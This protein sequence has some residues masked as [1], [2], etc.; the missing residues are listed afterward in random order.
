M[1][2]EPDRFTSIAIVEQRSQERG[3]NVVTFI[4]GFRMLV[5]FLLSAVLSL[6]P[7]VSEAAEKE[8]KDDATPIISFVQFQSPNLLAPQSPLTIKGKL[9]LPVH[10]DANQRCFAAR[11]DVPAVVILHGSNGVD[12]RG[13]FYAESLNAAGIATL[14]IDMWEAR[15]VVGA[16]NR[17]PLPLFTYPDAFS[18][19]A[20]LSA[21]PN[22]APGRIGVLGFSWGGV[23]S[24]ASAEQL[25]AGMFGGNTGLRFKAHVAHYPICYVYNK[26]DFP[27]PVPPTPAQAGIQF[28]N[29]TGAPVLIQIGT[30]DEYDNGPGHCRRLADSVNPGNVVEVAVYEDAFHAWDRIMIPIR[31]MDPFANE[32]SFF[33]TGVVPPVEI[34]ANVDEAYAARARAVRFFRR[35]LCRQSDTRSRQVVATALRSSAAWRLIIGEPILFSP[36][37]CGSIMFGALLGALAS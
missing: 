36:R 12:S 9:S 8:C 27:P 25:Y 7:T 32:G 23:I 5:Y 28:L 22:I 15:G 18:A 21:H 4:V 35:Q 19:L 29:L 11:R 37:L 2:V 16:L 6:M 34:K 3:G 20:F 26:T 31:V 13:D 30:E 33:K 24:V 17:P 1:Q 14:E 10:A